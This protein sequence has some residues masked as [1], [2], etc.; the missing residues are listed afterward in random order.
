MVTKDL[1]DI[2]KSCEIENWKEALTALLTYSS[3]KE[4]STLCGKKQ[5]SEKFENDDDET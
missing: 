3:A 4:F 5:G 1:G 2:V